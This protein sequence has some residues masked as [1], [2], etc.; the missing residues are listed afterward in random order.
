M[1]KPA[2]P[3]ILS[4]IPVATA[5]LYFAVLLCSLVGQCQPL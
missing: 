2:A 3:S 5:V 4:R 1:Y